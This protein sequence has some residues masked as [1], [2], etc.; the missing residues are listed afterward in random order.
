MPPQRTTGTNRAI[1]AAERRAG[2]CSAVNI[3]PLPQ[4]PSKLDLEIVQEARQHVAREAAEQPTYADAW[5][6]IDWSRLPGYHLPTQTQ[7]NRTGESWQHGYDI[8][9]ERDSTRHWYCKECHRIKHHRPH[10]YAG[11][12]TANHIKHLAQ[13]HQ[14]AIGK[15]AGQ[16]YRVSVIDQLQLAASNPQEQA[17]INT[18]IR[19][20]NPTYFFQLLIR[21]LVLTKM[22]FSAINSPHLRALLTYLNDAVRIGDCLPSHG[23][24]RSFVLKEYKRHKDTIKDIL[25]AA[26]GQLHFSMDIWTGRNRKSILG[27]NTHF[28]DASHKQRSIVL[29]L[30]ELL[31]LHQGTDIKD[32]VVAIFEAFGIR[33]IQ[34][35]YVMADNADNLDTFMRSMGN[36]GVDEYLQRLRCLGHIINLIVQQLFSGEWEGE[37]AEDYE[38]D[39]LEE[40]AVENLR[41][42]R[43]IGPIAK[44]R[45]IIM[46]LFN[47]EHRMRKLTRHQR[48]EINQQPRAPGCRPAKVLLPIKP[49]TTR[50][51]SLMSMMERAGK[52][53]NSIDAVVMEEVVEWQVYWNNLTRN[54]TRPPPTRRRPQPKIT[55]MMLSDDDWVVISQYTELLKPFKIATKRL[56]GRMSNGGHG[57]IWEVLPT[58]E[59]LLAHLEAAKVQYAHH[60]E[61]HF[62]E[63]I[64]LAWVKLNEYYALT[65]HSPAYIAAT[66]LHPSYKWRFVEKYWAPCYG[67]G[68]CPCP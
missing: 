33:P 14:I 49:I 2:P 55:E 62:K 6:G 37:F 68:L 57:S 51:N 22:P 16:P 46:W 59:L 9:K 63:N 66:V 1:L 3:T 36:W 60:P 10:I 52:I 41:L 64:N 27:I 45:Y 35:G 24:I 54:G 28:I 40:G 12:G 25:A 31:D 34:I 47:S 18:L 7:Y 48:T 58:F 42:W 65:D 50:W 11:T 43:R 30:P 5:S 23:T 15:N 39:L 61:Q 56:E 13:H 19:A 26:P 4:E 53:R 8:Q 29:A 44:L 32:V 38:Y 17:T 21:W 20:F 67:L